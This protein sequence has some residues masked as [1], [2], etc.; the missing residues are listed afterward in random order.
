M[1]FTDLMVICT[2]FL[3]LLC[4]IFFNVM[5]Q[6]YFIKCQL[7]AE[8]A[9]SFINYINPSFLPAVTWALSRTIP[10]NLTSIKQKSFDV[11]FRA[12]YRSRDLVILMAPKT[13]FLQ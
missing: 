8:V 2:M 5:M 1:K 12:L 11:I 7:L 9:L 6:Q 3:M 4:I 10:G 13:L